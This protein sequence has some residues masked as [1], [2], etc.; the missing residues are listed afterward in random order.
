MRFT[1][2]ATIKE[3][4]FSRKESWFVK[5]IKCLSLLSNVNYVFIIYDF[6]AMK[7]YGTV[8]IL[9]DRN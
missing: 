5:R 8:Q 2:D 7:K 3:Y 1:I 6:L 4:F 9:I